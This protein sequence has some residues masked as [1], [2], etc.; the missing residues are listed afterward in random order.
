MGGSF[1]PVVVAVLILVPEQL[2]RLRFRGAL[3]CIRQGFTSRAPAPLLFLQHRHT[4]V[5]KGISSFGFDVEFCRVV[6]HVI[7]PGG[8][9][10][11]GR[12]VVAGGS[13]RNS[14]GLGGTCLV[15]KPFCLYLLCVGDGLSVAAFLQKLITM[16]AELASFGVE[17][18]E[19][20]GDSR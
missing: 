2:Q 16:K 19:S 9:L 12:V 14:L 1:L 18:H 17:I 20:L 5:N 15:H 13:E 7:A 3:L 6:A 8:D 11:Q 4:R 10:L